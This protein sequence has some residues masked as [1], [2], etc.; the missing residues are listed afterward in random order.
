MLQ[1]II[2]F[3]QNLFGGLFRTKKVEPRPTI[4]TPPPPS[5]RADEE[6]DD[7]YVDD[8]IPQDGADI[9]ENDIETTEVEVPKTEEP[10]P[11]EPEED[12]SEEPDFLPPPI[13]PEE[14]PE[15]E[16]VDETPTHEPRFLW[17][18][19]NGHGRFTRGKR[20]PVFMDGRQFLEYEFNRDIV[21]K[22]IEKLEQKGVQYFNVVPEVDIDNFL[23]G[24]VDRANDKKSDL[25]KL[26]VS[27]HANAASAES[28]NHWS[29][30]GAKGIETW[31]FKGSRRGEKLA[32]IFQKHLIKKTGFKNR[33]LKAT[34][35]LFV[36]R[37]TKMTSVLTENG[38]FNNKE[39][40]KMLMLDNV[41]QKIA[42]AHV[43]AILEVE[44]NGL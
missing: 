37:K 10:A 27:I 4:P 11:S 41:R 29:T 35:K 24:R 33:N 3:F 30:S 12:E 44:K 13:L 36:L 39:E 38:F 17:C 34:T 7:D 25:P 14:F 42:D 26:Y 18:L 22:I 20:S 43:N 9:G 8:N 19:D 6:I 31:F 16:S 40:A 15:T 28:I 32:G 1:K 23:S 2:E 5:P 21:K